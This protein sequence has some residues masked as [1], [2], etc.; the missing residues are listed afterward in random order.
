MPH[1]GFE[2]QK[3]RFA[4]ADHSAIVTTK[5]IRLIETQ[6]VCCSNIVMKDYLTKFN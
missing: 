5:G 4:G 6:S 1:P 3:Y 2:P